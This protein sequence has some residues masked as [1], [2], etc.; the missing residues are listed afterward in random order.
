VW[1][2]KT[3]LDAEEKLRREALARRLAHNRGELA[4]L[5]ARLAANGETHPLFDMAGRTRDLEESIRRTWRE[6]AG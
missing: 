3:T 6:F 4:A 2:L 1:L 5:R